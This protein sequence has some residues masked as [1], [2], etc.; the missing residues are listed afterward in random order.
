MLCYPPS[1]DSGFAAYPLS[2]DFPFRPT[3]Y[4][5]PAVVVVDNFASDGLPA[6][7]MPA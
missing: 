5:V 6:V 1:R 3:R 4:P 2:R 7:P